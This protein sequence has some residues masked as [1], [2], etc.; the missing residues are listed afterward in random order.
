M[1]YKKKS[2]FESKNINPDTNQAYST[3]FGCISL[4]L[5]GL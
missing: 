2:R 5:P 4:V 3:L 1:I